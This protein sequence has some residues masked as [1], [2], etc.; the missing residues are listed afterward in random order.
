MDTP[1]ASGTQPLIRELLVEVLDFLLCQF[2]ECR[3]F[4][5]R[6]NVV[7]EQ[8][9]IAVFCVVCQLPLNMAIE[10]VLRVAADGDAGF[11]HGYSSFR[12]TTHITEKRKYPDEILRKQIRNKKREFRILVRNS[13]VITHFY[14][15]EIH[16]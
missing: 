11:F 7:E 15:L 8:I 16:G 6:H 1:D 3:A 9:S 14:I 2:D 5:V 13:L 10:P 12:N 4:E